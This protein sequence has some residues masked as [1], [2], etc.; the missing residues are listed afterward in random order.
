MSNGRYIPLRI[1]TY[2]IYAGANPKLL[3]GTTPEQVPAVTAG[4]YD[5]FLSTDYPARARRIA[6]IIACARP[7]IIGLQEVDIVTYRSS[8]RRC[9]TDFLRILLRDLED[10]GV[11]YCAVSVND[12]FGTELPSITG[13]LIGL[14]ERDMILVR[15]D[16]PFIITNTQSGNFQTNLV[17]PIGGESFT[18]LRG[19]SS[20]DIRMYGTAYRVV[21]THLDGDS[22]AVRLAQ[23][24]ELLDGP[25]NTGM[26]V[27]L[28]GDYNSDADTGGAVYEL[29]LDAGFTDAWTVAGRGPG[30]TAAQAFDLRNPVSELSE[31][32]D[33]ILYRD[34]FA[35]EGIYTVGDRQRD[36]TP[37]GLWPS[38]HAG[39]LADLLV[40]HSCGRSIPT[41]C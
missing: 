22:E 17:V 18:I 7:D 33:L 6:D 8:R 20:A 26:P 5:Q 25:A 32:I 3:V 10:R 23:A 35:T 27:L 28:I 4:I 38:A 36:R 2:N 24:E 1:M 41:I 21:N 34:H 15:R 40:R 9:V 31:R 19:W 37:G 12:N 13:A 39:V 14:Y 11:S 29:L 16:A 30:Y